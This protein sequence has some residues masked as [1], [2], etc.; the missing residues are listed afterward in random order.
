[1][2]VAGA[3]PASAAKMV[4][5][6]RTNFTE[7]THLGKVHVSLD[8][9]Q[10]AGHRQLMGARIAVNGQQLAWP[11]DLELRI[12]DPNIRQMSLASTASYTCIGD[13]C[14]DISQWP[15]LLI[16][17]FGEIVNGGEDAKCDRSWLYIGILADRIE[18]IS[19]WDC[20]QGDAE[21]PD[22]HVLFESD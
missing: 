18:E 13:E 5:P 17:P 10:L 4:K 22:E 9:K 21:E 16:I 20:P 19:R 3:C 2:W 14:P 1:M 7:Q 6:N 8:I 15:A 12:A 11:A